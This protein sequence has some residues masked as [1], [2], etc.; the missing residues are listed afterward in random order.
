MIIE[1]TTYEVPLSVYKE[2]SLVPWGGTVGGVVVV[3]VRRDQ[4]V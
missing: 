4:S 1:L 3:V 2:Q